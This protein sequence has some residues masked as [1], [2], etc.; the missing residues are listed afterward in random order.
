[1][2]VEDF[3][4]RIASD[5]RSGASE[6]ASRA[7]QLFVRLEAESEFAT[8]SA[9]Q[10]AIR[11]AAVSLVKT[12]PCMAT[13][14]NL[15]GAVMRAA[16]SATRPED[17]L[18]VCVRA[19]RE[20]N[21]AC[22]VAGAT[23]AQHASSFIADNMILLTHSRSSTILR[24]MLEAHL[25]GKKFGVIVTESR[26]MQEGRTL[27]AELAGSGIKVT[28]IA[29]LAAASVM[30]HVSSVLVGADLITSR[31][32]VNKIGTRMIAL[33]AKE[34]SV[35]IFAVADSSKFINPLEHDLPSEPE[36]E[37]GELW[38]AAPPNVTVMNRYFEKT[39]LDYFVGIITEEGRLTLESVRRRTEAALVDPAL[40]SALRGS[41]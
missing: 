15:A 10:S 34:R 29:D 18:K 11:D 23:A 28:L 39:P 37:R 30:P 38:P 40:I 25:A 13:L 5:N 33:A 16:S 8:A 1:V 27:A 35:P 24:A 17:V 12:Q 14:I 3:L 19:S 21:E 31:A 6:L 36:R 20:F 9:A 7:A 4:R 2:S 41:A 22:R 26:P 32:V